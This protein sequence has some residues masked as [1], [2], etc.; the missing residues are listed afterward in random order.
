MR[1][2]KILDRYFTTEFASYFIFGAS[3]VVVFL[4]INTV[5]FQM[6]EF[7]IDKRVPVVDV[8][9]ILFYQIPAFAV[10]AFPMATL[11]ATLISINRMSRDSE[12]DVMRTSGISVVRILIPMLVMGLF[13]SICSFGILQRIVPMANAKSASLWR[14]FAMSEVMSK[15]MADIFFRGLGTKNFY[16]KSI[17]PGTNTLHGIMIYDTR[18]GQFPVVTTAP[19]GF[20]DNK[21]ISLRNGTI[22]HFGENGKLDYSAD[23]GELSIDIE[24]RL[25]QIFG[26]QKTAQELTYQQLQSQIELFRRSGMNAKSLETDLQFK[27]SVPVAS[28]ICVLVGVPLSI[29]TGRSSMTLGIAVSVGLILLYWVG[30]IICTALGHKGVLPPAV[31][32]W[33]QNALFFVV[34]IYLIIRT[35]K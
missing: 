1:I 34:G 24:R 35:R 29:R 4:M 25:E 13:V 30:T 33:S 19:Y 14:K 32:A 17:D 26:D 23:F 7:V 22:H 16:I 18:E 8:A 5:L 20:W 9:R 31:A 21:N 27:L 15:P 12:I 2:L 3:L 11:F 6:M 28:F 10:V